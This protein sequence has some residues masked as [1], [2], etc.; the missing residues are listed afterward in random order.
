VVRRGKAGSSQNP[1]NKVDT[2]DTSKI[3]SRGA[4]LARINRKLTAGADPVRL[5]SRGGHYA[6]ECQRYGTTTQVP[7]GTTLEELARD[8]GV[9]RAGES[10]TE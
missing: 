7:G 6:Y 10:V 3:V 8:H 4:A 9:L 2:M 1:N 5:H